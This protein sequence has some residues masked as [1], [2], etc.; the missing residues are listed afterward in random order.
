MSVTLQTHFGL[1]QCYYECGRNFTAGL[2]K[3]RSHNGLRN[4]LWSL[5]AYRKLMQKFEMIDLLKIRRN[6]EDL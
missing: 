1:I 6:W 5:I 2:R 3:F 4:D